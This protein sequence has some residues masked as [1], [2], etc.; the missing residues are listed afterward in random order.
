M[1]C[2]YKDALG[3]PGEGVHS[4]RFLGV[5]VVDVVMTVVVAYVVHRVMGYP[6]GRTV[7]VAFLLGVFSHWL[8]CVDT[9]VARVL[10]EGFDRLVEDLGQVG[11]QGS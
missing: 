9:T 5:A 8:F 4:Y 2:Q 11:A 7:A 1:L 6:F 3:R 10:G